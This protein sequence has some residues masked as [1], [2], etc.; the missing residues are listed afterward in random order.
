[1]GSAGVVALLLGLG[2]PGVPVELGQAVVLAPSLDAVGVVVA[3]AGPCRGTRRVT[4]LL[5]LHGFVDELAVAAQV[6]G[7]L[8]VRLLLRH[9]RRLVL[10]QLVSEHFK[11]YYGKGDAF[12]NLNERSYKATNQSH[13]ILSSDQS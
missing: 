3:G 1:M 7:L 4:H 6:V 9:A 12:H 10:E 13:G 11:Y 5:D 8:Q 2:L